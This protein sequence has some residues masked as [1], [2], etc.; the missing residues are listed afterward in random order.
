VV[1]LVSYY[2]YNLSRMRWA[3]HVARVRE[4][5]HAYEIL[6]WKSEG[7]SPFDNPKRRYEYIIKMDVQNVV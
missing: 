7:K 5:R 4:M 1:R 6:V 3:G 2:S